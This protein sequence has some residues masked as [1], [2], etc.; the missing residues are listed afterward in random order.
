MHCALV[1]AMGTQTDKQK[2]SNK[3]MRAIINTVRKEA[4]RLTKSGPKTNTFQ[5]FRQVLSENNRPVVTEADLEGM[6]LSQQRVLLEGKREMAFRTDVSQRWASTIVMLMQLLTN[7]SSLTLMYTAGDRGNPLEDEFSVILQV[8]SICFRVLVFLRLSQG[9]HSCN[10]VRVVAELRYLLL[11]TLNMKEKLQ[12]Y[13]P[14]AVPQGK[15]LFDEDNYPQTEYKQAS[16]LKPVASD[17]RQR[18][19]T[20]V[21]KRFLQEDYAVKKHNHTCDYTIDMCM[22]LCPLHTTGNTRRYRGPHQR[23]DAHSPQES[24][25]SSQQGARVRGG[26]GRQKTE[27]TITLELHS[28]ECRGVSR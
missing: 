3:E 9:T 20:A 23:D 27:T 5:K 16:S 18:L 15:N 1:E 12:I 28:Q 13:N 22:Y 7:W 24:N 25:G 4:E 10:T 26:S 19:R 6:T 11:H 21:V 8:F 14:A 2:S 17:A